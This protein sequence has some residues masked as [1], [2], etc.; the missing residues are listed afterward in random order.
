MVVQSE[1]GRSAFGLAMYAAGNSKKSE[2]RKVT[3]FTWT[4]KMRKDQDGW[5]SFGTDVE[6]DDAVLCE[7]CLLVRF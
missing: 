3:L 1:K 7:K 2:I 4:R 5:W 6:G